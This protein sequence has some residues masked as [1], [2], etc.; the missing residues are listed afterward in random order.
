MNRSATR[1][2][3]VTGL[4][5]AA[6]A[7]AAAAPAAAEVQLPDHRAWER[8]T[9]NGKYGNGNFL[10]PAGMLNDVM[11]FS[12]LAPLPPAESGT[13][14]MYRATRS[15]TGWDLEAYFAGPYPRTYDAVGSL[16]FNRD[17]NATWWRTF[18]ETEGSFHG[19]GLWRRLGTGPAHR[20]TDVAARGALPVQLLGVSDDGLRAAFVTNVALTSNDT[21]NAIDVYVYDEHDQPHLV[22]VKDDGTPISSC[23]VIDISAYS[24]NGS[25]A[26]NHDADYIVSDDLDTVFFQSSDGC[27]TPSHVY[28]RVGL[29]HTIDVSAS[30]R[31]TPDPAGP[32]PIEFVGGTP[33]GHRVLFHTT[34]QLVDE[35]TDHGDDLYR[36]DLQTGR[37]D[38]VT[39]GATPGEDPG[40]LGPMRADADFSHAY[41]VADGQY[42]G[43]G[44]PGAPNLFVW[45]DGHTRFIATLSPNEQ[46][47]WGNAAA[48]RQAQVTPDGN[49][50]VFVTTARLTPTDLDDAVD[51]YGYDAA[52]GTLKQLS[53]G[54]GPFDVNIPSG[55][56]TYAGHGLGAVRVI[57]DDG[58]FGT[59][60]TDEGIDVQDGNARADVYRWRW[61]DGSVALVSGGTGNPTGTTFSAGV[62]PD[63]RDIYVLTDEALLPTDDDGVAD[64]YTAHIDG[65]FPLPAK[66]APPCQGEGCQGPLA[67]PPALAEPGTGGVFGPGEAAAPVR[68]TLGVRALSASALRAAA[69]SGRLTLTVS[70][71]QPATVI[72]VAKARIGKS[73]AVVARGTAQLARAG[74]GT[75][76]LTLTA[77]ARRQLKRTRK[78]A[79]AI[80][81][82]SSSSRTVKDLAPTLRLKKRAAR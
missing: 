10:A 78:L 42:G 74:T 45:I 57:S 6:I 63:G 21:D 12:T 65:G 37:L 53:T 43:Q 80:H 17:L 29:T 9:P 77:T 79:L 58:R 81:V 8:V 54:N 60:D 22:S 76:K 2:R 71:N 56:G 69:T 13:G 55:T 67:S 64:I 30:Q 15:A 14:N 62:S 38:L 20:V 41:F 36:Y 40:Y 16:Y 59:F 52:T 27:G 51:L 49:R 32:Q 24:Q 35:D 50:V 68:G 31:S 73:T 34:E 23:G 11:V 7:L 39:A 1:L 47:G 33:D 18:S 26:Q 44:T 75:V 5:M 72:A 4:A 48:S 28:A 66:P 25:P 82:T 70:V 46:L 3:R 19:T 61:D